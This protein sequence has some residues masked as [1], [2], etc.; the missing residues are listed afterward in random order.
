MDKYKLIFNP[1]SR[2]GKSRQDIPYILDMLKSYDIDYNFTETEYPLHAIKIAEESIKEYD[3]ILAVGGDGTINEII[4]GMAGSD[5]Y[6]GIIPLGSGN[7]FIKTLGIPHNIDEA[8][9]IVKEKNSSRI[10]LGKAGDR[11][12]SNGVG[13]GFDAVATD[14]KIKLK[15]I[16][17]KYVYYLAILKTLFKY[18]PTEISVTVNDATMRQRFYLVSIGNGKYMGGGF[19]LNPDASFY[20]GELNICMIDEISKLTV[21][22][23]ISKV[24]KGT[25]GPLKIVKMFRSDK[26]VIESEEGFPVQ[27]DGELYSLNEKKLEITIIPNSL[28]V[29]IKQ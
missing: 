25:H 15:K 14:E 20:D 9:K 4:N 23:H 7:D 16:H 28:N 2:N 18:Q 3:I 19:M 8:I 5:R 26:V 21:I 11:F 12:F 29:L 24:I 6:L 22:K 10:D 13:I 27:M 17:E 1:A